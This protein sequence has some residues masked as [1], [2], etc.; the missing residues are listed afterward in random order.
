MSLVLG[1]DLGVALE[2]APLDKGMEVPSG[3]RPPTPNTI[4]PANSDV[5]EGF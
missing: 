1:K 3:V 4:A 2:G 5:E